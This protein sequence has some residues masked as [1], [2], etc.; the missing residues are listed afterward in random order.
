MSNLVKEENGAQMIE[1]PVYEIKYSANKLEVVRTCNKRENT[2]DIL[3]D[4]IEPIIQKFN[5]NYNLHPR[6]NNLK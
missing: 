3:S 1:F 2:P 4:Y 6:K 5:K